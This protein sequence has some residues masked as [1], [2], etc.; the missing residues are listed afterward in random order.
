MPFSNGTSRRKSTISKTVRIKRRGGGEMTGCHSSSKIPSHCKKRLLEPIKISSKSSLRWQDLHIAIKQRATQVITGCRISTN[1]YILRNWHQSREC[2]S[3]AG[4]KWVRWA[5]RAGNNP[6]GVIGAHPCTGA[7][8]A[9][10]S[11]QNKTLTTL[12][13]RAGHSWQQK[14]E[15]R[16]GLEIPNRCA[17]C[18]AVSCLLHEQSAS[19]VHF[20]SDFSSTFWF[21]T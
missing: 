5:G 18:L 15:P 19:H 4:K 20:W 2:R 3:G 1:L 11:G 12:I 14:T 10:I 8:P 7:L 21:L 13:C 6:V 9:A 16:E 17:T